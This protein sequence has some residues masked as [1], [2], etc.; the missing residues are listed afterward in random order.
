MG[1]KEEVRG[2]GIMTLLIPVRLHNIKYR[3]KRRWCAGF[4][5]TGMTAEFNWIYAASSD[6]SASNSHNWILLLV[7]YFPK[8]ST[9]RWY[10]WSSQEYLHLERHGNDS[11]RSGFPNVL[12]AILFSC[13]TVQSSSVRGRVSS[14]LLVTANISCSAFLN[15]AQH[16][17]GFIHVSFQSETFI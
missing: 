6:Q 8:L 16:L 12:W 15:K 14:T 17:W 11:Q 10:H 13:M 5:M 9:E 4:K 7:I 3:D 1:A 2:L